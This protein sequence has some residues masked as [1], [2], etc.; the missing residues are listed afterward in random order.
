MVI[1]Y[2]IYIFFSHIKY[3]DLFI[4]TLHKPHRLCH[5]ILFY[6]SK[7]TLNNI[8]TATKIIIIDNLIILI[9]IF[10]IY[11]NLNILM[12]FILINIHLYRHFSIYYQLTS[13]TIASLVLQNYYSSM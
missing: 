7:L 1:F 3:E 11:L 12:F 5:L 8:R 10:K 4:I 2:L 6:R 13:S 9:Y